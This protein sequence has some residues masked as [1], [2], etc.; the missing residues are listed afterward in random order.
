M[1]DGMTAM[2]LSA[3]L[4]QKINMATDSLCQIALNQQL[5]HKSENW[6]KFSSHIKVKLHKKKLCTT[7]PAYI[8]QSD[9]SL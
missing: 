7:R 4:L 2:S 8:P 6:C 9:P 1:N 3:S 5:W